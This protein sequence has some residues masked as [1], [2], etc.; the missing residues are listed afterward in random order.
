MTPA[1][2]VSISESMPRSRRSSALSVRVCQRRACRV[3]PA[4]TWTWPSMPGVEPHPRID[5][6][7]LAEDGDGSGGEAV[8][9]GGTR[10]SPG[11]T[12]RRRGR[13]G[14]CPCR[15]SIKPASSSSANA[16]RTVVRDR[17]NVSASS[18][19]GR[20][21]FPGGQTA[22]LDVVGE[23]G[24]KPG[25]G[26]GLD[27]APAGGRQSGLWRGGGH[28]E[29]E[30]R[31]RVGGQLNRAR[32]RVHERK[33]LVN[34]F[35]QIKLVLERGF[36]GVPAITCR[37]L[38]GWPAGDRTHIGLHICRSSH[39]G[40]GG[41]GTTVRAQ[42]DRR[43]LPVNDGWS[44]VQSGTLNGPADSHGGSHGER[45]HESDPHRGARPRTGP[46]GATAGR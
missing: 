23:L 17:E 8:A 42:N 27:Q 2:R 32:F 21:H 3:L 30:E 22:G 24:R 34:H 14:R 38:R 4:A 13:G 15:H 9:S 33:P 11:G 29:S 43:W 36:I 10:Q 31:E 28:R 39:G 7:R 26:L 5:V 1:G 19:L 46:A 35:R 25:A 12:R 44:C 45:R 20:Q 41:S 37:L 16:R 40:K 6:G 18:P